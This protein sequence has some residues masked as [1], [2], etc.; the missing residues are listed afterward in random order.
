MKTSKNNLAAVFIS[1]SICGK[2]GLI[3]SLELEMMY[4]LTHHHF[5]MS[6]SEFESAI[7]YFFDSH[8]QVDFHIAQ[9]TS[10]KDQNKIKDKVLELKNKKD[11]SQPTKIKTSGS[12]FKNP[13]HQTNKKVWQLIKESVSL[14]TSFGGASISSKHCNFFINKNNASFND[15][16]KLIEFVRESVQKKTG[17]KLE[18]EIKILK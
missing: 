8:D 5:M 2:D 1:A 17:I 13:I 4:S 18:R 7:D 11:N 9:V 16:Y 15:M 12:T 3:S 14:D 6:K 10:K